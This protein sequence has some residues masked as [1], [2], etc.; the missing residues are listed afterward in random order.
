M[1]NDW[2]IS[3]HIQTVQTRTAMEEAKKIAA[4]ALAKGICGRGFTASLSS[5]PPKRATA[6]GM[7]ARLTSNVGHR[8]SACV[9][10]RSMTRN[11]EDEMSFPAASNTRVAHNQSITPSA[12]ENQSG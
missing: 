10:A 6:A 1:L 8:A 3:T 9:P 2:Y 4:S 11:A 7:Q 5:S 12:R